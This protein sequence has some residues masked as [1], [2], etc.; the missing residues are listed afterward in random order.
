V[1]GVE[2][3]LMDGCY[4]CNPKKDNVKKQSDLSYVHL[5]GFPVSKYHLTVVSLRHV[6]SLDELTKEEL[7]DVWYNVLSCKKWLSELDPTIKGFNIGINDGECAGQM[8][9]HLHIHLIPRRVGDV[10]NPKGGVRNIF[11]QR[12]DWSKEI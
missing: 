11:P 9:P 5:D 1:S 3:N 12:G 4:F 10:K 6:Q 2:N 8:I 7:D